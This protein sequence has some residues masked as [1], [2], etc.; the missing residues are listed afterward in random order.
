L[1]ASLDNSTHSGKKHTL[2]FGSLFVG[3]QTSLDAESVEALTALGREADDAKYGE[4]T[5]F[6]HRIEREIM[7]GSCL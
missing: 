2:P 3:P 6:I 4:E 1:E 5:V 7:A